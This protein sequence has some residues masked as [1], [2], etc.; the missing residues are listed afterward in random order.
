MC[1]CL[2]EKVPP[3]MRKSSTNSCRPTSMLIGSGSPTFG[4]CGG[5]LA[6]YPGSTYTFEIG[7]R[8]G[9]S[10]GRQMLLY[11]SSP[12]HDAEVLA[13]AV[14]GVDDESQAAASSSAADRF[15]LAVQCISCRS[16][17][18]GGACRGGGGTLER[19]RPAPAARAARLRV[20]ICR[21]YT[22]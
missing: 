10:F 16:R 6:T 3:S 13:P 5:G 14:E 18:A 20:R 11:S 12:G 8:G 2:T 19:A 9:N 17:V 22:V 15:K 21:E 1:Y 4:A 7:V